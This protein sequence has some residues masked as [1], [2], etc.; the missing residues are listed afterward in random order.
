MST[1]INLFEQI[2]K[3]WPVK[4]IKDITKEK[5]YAFCF[6]YYYMQWPSSLCGPYYK[7]TLEEAEQHVI[8]TYEECEERLFLG[9][10]IDGRVVATIIEVDP[11][12]IKE[13][14]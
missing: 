4:M 6:D 5:H 11:E 12:D 13:P 8:K 2:V 9:D 10:P 1:A 7:A 3:N 14:E